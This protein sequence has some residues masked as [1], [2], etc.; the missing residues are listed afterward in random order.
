[1]R[2]RAYGL[3]PI[4]LFA[5]LGIGCGGNSGKT[6]LPSTGPW[7]PLK[8]GN[9]WTYTITDVDGKVSAKVQGVTAESA[10]GGT[11]MFASAMAFKLVTGDRFDDKNGDVSYQNWVNS[12]LVRYREL[13]VGASSGNT[14]K[15]EYYEPPRLRLDDTD[16]HNKAGANWPESYKT[17][18]VDTPKAP[19]DA[20]VPDGG[21]VDAGL[22]TTEDMIIDVWTVLAVDEEVTVPAGTFKA[23][24]VE[25][26]GNSGASDKKFWFARGVGKVKETGV[27]DQTE[28]LSS[29]ML[30]P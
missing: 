9:R 25:K 17:F 24:V 30:M 2:T 21:A 29:Y 23:M 27:N 11:G 16:E 1:M 13:S 12:R 5:G 26:V 28:E 10:V 18:T 7:V 15:E 14:K 6:P 4:L 8:V 3:L 20:G 19:A 22:V